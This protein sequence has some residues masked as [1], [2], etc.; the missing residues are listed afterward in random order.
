LFTVE[1]GFLA[2]GLGRWHSG[3]KSAGS[4]VQHP[5]CPVKCHL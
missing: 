4:P 2:A 1:R 3:R 5:P